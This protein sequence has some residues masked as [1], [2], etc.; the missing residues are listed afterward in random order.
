M[1]DITQTQRIILEMAAERPDGAIL[2]LSDRLT[3]NGGALAKTLDSLKRKGLIT[4]QAHADGET[5][6]IT[7]E[8]RAAVGKERPVPDADAGSAQA[9]RPGTK[10]AMLV[11]L[12]E[13]P[14]GAT[15]AEM[16]DATGWLPHTTRAAL[17]GLR[18]RGLTI[19][20]CKEDGRGSVYRIGGEEAGS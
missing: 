10:Q 13:R 6:L 12:L 17:T 18:K 19:A 20:R 2:P 14:K 5:V 1:P 9:I 11:K 7:A 15:I 8:G 3:L 4:T 16:V